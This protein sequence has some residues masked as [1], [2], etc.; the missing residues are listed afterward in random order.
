[1]HQLHVVTSC[2]SMGFEGCAPPLSSIF[3]ISMYFSA[4][5]MP[6]NR[7]MSPSGLVPLLALVSPLGNPGTATDNVTSFEFVFDG[8]VRGLT[9][10]NSV[11][12]ILIEQIQRALTNVIISVS[13]YSITRILELWSRAEHRSSF[14]VVFGLVTAKWP[15]LF[16]WGDRPYWA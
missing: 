2:G 7:V 12:F 6:N 3:F 10:Q 8:C 5:I 4:K 16:E 15:V 14:I 1:M 11:P 13:V 9:D